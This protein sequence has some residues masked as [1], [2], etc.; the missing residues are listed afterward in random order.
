MADNL[1]IHEGQTS[2]PQLRTKDTGSGHLP[3]NLVGQHVRVYDGVQSIT[4]SSVSQSL[5]VPANATFADITC[6]STS[7]TTDYCRFWPDGTV[8][9][10][11]VGH[12][13]GPGTAEGAFWESAAPSTF[14]AIN[15][16]GSCTLRIS[17]FHYA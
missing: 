16:A 4:L 6:E 3:I 7:P 13:L 17:Y 15:S 12:K 11:S 2:D 8:P 10:A 14:K 1:H 9:T 5:T